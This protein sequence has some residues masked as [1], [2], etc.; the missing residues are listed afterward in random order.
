MLIL[1]VMAAAFALAG[2]GRRHEAYWESWTV[3]NLLLGVALC[4]YIFEP[5]LPPLLVAT[6]PNGLLVLGFGFRWRAA[7]EFSGRPASA[8]FIWG[9]FALFVASAVPWAY[10]SYATVFTVANIH[11]TILSGAVACEFWR[12]R[13][14][15]LP[16]RHGLV[17]AYGLMAA[18]FAF[19]IAQGIMEANTMPGHLPHDM[20]LVVHLTIAVIHTT[21]SGAF[22]LSLAYERGNAALRHL[23]DH[24]ALTGLVNRG[25]FE[26][27]VRERLAG[28]RPF[29]L[30]MLDIDHFK[31]INDRH[32]HAAGDEALRRCADVLRGMVRPGDA[33]A[34]I[35]GEEFAIVLD[36]ADEGAALGLLERIRREIGSTVIGAGERRF[37]V[38]ISGGVCRAERDAD[39]T[40]LM[41]VADACLYAAKHKGR[42]RIEKAAA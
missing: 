38:T 35:G 34:R 15:G 5:R 24:D 42:N 36:A 8:L 26:A 23:A 19:R 18:S 12:D 29:S 41:R 31:L 13:G 40:Q 16:S 11:L 33:V 2:R 10:S 1:W 17:A 3:A 14:D 32:G 21:A 20:A 37:R 6:L 22:A 4:V 30:A 9:P 28:G 25:A 39:F 27:A 7:R